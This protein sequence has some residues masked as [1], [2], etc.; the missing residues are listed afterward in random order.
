[1]IYEYCFS[2]WP[3][4]TAPRNRQCEAVFKLFEMMA[5]RHGTGR[6]PGIAKSVC[7]Q[8]P[9]TWVV[10]TDC[11]P[12]RDGNPVAPHGWWFQV[13]D[14]H[15]EHVIER[16]IWDLLKSW[17]N[18]GG[19]PNLLKW[20]KTKDRALA[21]LSNAAVNYGRRLAGL[22]E[23][24][25]VREKENKQKTSMTFLT[26]LTDEQIEQIENYFSQQ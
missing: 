26:Q 5:S 11:Q 2:V 19:P 18:Y 21:A 14:R 9:V 10:L 17:H 22:P 15:N 6:T 3:D 4:E 12:M 23:L 8:W 16:A 20:Y 1:M 25:F 24:S 13:N 7:E